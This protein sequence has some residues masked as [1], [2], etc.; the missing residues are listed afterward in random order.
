MKHIIWF[1]EN[2]K[3]VEQ[4]D[5]PLTMKTAE[6]I[7]RELRAEVG[8]IYKVLPVGEVPSLKTTLHEELTLVELR[9]LRDKAVEDQ[10]LPRAF[11]LATA[12]DRARGLY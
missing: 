2:G 4:G 8:G 1:K 12:I 6:R 5:G 11:K 10:D 3:W 7:V 9:V